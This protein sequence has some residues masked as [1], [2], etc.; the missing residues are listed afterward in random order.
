MNIIKES[1]NYK[2]ENVSVS[3]NRLK[4][5]HSKILEEEIADKNELI[6]TLDRKIKF[7]EHRIEYYKFKI[8][9][10]KQERRTMR[11]VLLSCAFINI[12]ISIL[13]LFN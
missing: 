12:I 6:K 2:E 13:R 11:T 7:Y 3:V 9:H 8:E 4:A 5:Y 1:L 10:Y